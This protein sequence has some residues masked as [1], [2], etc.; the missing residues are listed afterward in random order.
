[1]YINLRGIAYG[2]SPFKEGLAL[3][4]R[5]LIQPRA[6]GPRPVVTP[7]GVASANAKRINTLSKALY[8]YII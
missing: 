2:D 4:S 3:P 6:T 1:M 7:E 5:A 8:R